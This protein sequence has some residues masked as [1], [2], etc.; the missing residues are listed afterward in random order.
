MP[1]WCMNALRVEGEGAKDFIKNLKEHGMNHFVPMPEI[2]KKI[3]S[4]PESTPEDKRK[5]VTKELGAKD[6]EDALKI[7]KEKYHATNW[8]DWRLTNWGTKWD[9]CEQH[10]GTKREDV[11]WF[12]TAWGPPLAFLETVSKQYPDLLFWM[13]YYE[14]GMVFGGHFIAYKNNVWD[15]YN[16]SAVPMWFPNDEEEPIKLKVGH[17]LPIH[18]KII[19]IG[20]KNVKLE[21]VAGT[22]VVLS[23]EFYDEFFGEP[24]IDYPGF[25]A[26]KHQEFDP[27][28]ILEVMGQEE[29]LGEWELPNNSGI[30]LGC[31]INIECEDHEQKRKTWGKG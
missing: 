6:W 22:E 30:T 8:Y 14:P 15:I 23:R 9:I 26:L 19:N 31:F 13:E 1:N 12:D 7:L 18:Y 28:L 11:L 17:T 2:F 3:T 24:L 27:P 20:K 10:F 21:T 4:P 16:S 25:C 5:E 29:K